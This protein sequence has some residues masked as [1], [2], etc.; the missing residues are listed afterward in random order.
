MKKY[1]KIVV[2]FLGVLL[3]VSCHDVTTDGI[4]KVTYYVTFEMDGDE[5]FLLPVGEDYVEPGVKAIENGEDVS[6]KMDTDNPV[7]KD[8]VG[9]Y[10][11]TYSAKNADGFS[12][13]VTRQVIVYDPSITTDIAGNYSVDLSYSHR[14]QFSNGATI[15]YANMQGLYGFG[16][17]S[18]YVV[19]LTKIAPGIFSVSD[20]FSGYYVEGRGYAK[21]YAM[22]GYISLKSDDT[23]DLLSSIVA[24]W[25]DSLY[26]LEDG[27]YDPATESL[28]W[29]AV[30]P[31]DDPLYSFNVKLN[32]N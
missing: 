12:N 30:Y 20:L 23:I 29:G 17:F 32:K 21:T 25:G 16:D 28:E 7:D 3:F 14:L 19:A 9:L 2:L 26:D 6:S 22:T 27:V 15:M 4:S 24:G 5:L 11:I 18:T 31:Y 8:E 13:S 10:T 1:S